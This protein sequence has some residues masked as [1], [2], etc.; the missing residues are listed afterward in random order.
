MARKRAKGTK[1][2]TQPATLSKVSP[3]LSSGTKVKSEASTSK[4]NIVAEF[5]GYFGKESR[6]ANWQRLCRDVGIEDELR[7]ITQCRNV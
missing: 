6:L 3:K 5:D 7:S 2:D 4:R 1:R